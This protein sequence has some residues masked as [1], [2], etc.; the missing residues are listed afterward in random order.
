MPHLVNESSA[1]TVRA[2]FYNNSNALSAPNSARYSIR[3]ITNDRTVRDW[4]TLTALDTVDI[5]ITADDNDILESGRKWKRFEKRVITVQA[6][7]GEDTQRTEE[8]EYWVKNLHG[9]ED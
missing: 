6:N 9:V 8:I 7:A 3:D 5:E 2:R 4:T 1:M